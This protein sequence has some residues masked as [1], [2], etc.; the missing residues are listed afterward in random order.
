MIDLERCRAAALRMLRHR[1]NSESELR[2]KLRARRFD[3]ET[4]DE[5]IARL[6]QEKWLD[7]ERFASAF[8]RSRQHRGIGSRR[9]ARELGAAGVDR[10]TARAALAE[11][12][13]A[14]AEV[15]ALIAH[16]RKRSRVLI[17]RHGADYLQSADGRNKLAAYLLKQGYDAALVRRVLEEIPPVED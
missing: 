10:E 1:F 16:Y 5:T 13:D 14:E 17:R 3:R 2:L 7:D 6:R 15:A 9:I 11:N 8:V 4:I 12:A